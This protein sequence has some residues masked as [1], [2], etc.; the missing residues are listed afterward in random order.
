[1]DTLEE[2]LISNLDIKRMMENLKILVKK[3]RL[4]GTQEELEGF[5]YV[6]KKV[7]EYG[8]DNKLLT[9]RGYLSYPRF[10]KVEVG[11]DEPLTLQAKTRSFSASTSN[12]GV[13]GDV[14]YIPG[15]SDMFTDTKTI[16]MLRINRGWWTAEYDF[17]SEKRSNRL[18]PYV[19]QSRS[20]GS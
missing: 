9:F 15:G 4:S 17:C 5:Q 19:A 3:P 1:M 13:E 12:D 14:V 11:G 10:A 16:E 6:Q 8:V 18:Y 7:T 2:E 20:S